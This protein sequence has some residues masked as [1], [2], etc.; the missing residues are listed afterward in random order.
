MLVLLEENFL[1]FFFLKLH[2][3]NWK[4]VGEFTEQC[5]SVRFDFGFFI[6]VIQRRITV[7]IENFTKHL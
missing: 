1:K 2:R 7:R 5:F 6:F 4:K 3:Q